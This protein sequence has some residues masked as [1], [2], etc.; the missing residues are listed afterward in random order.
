MVKRCLFCGRFF[1]ADPRVKNQKA[2]WREQCKKARKQ[3]AQSNWCKNNSN[4]FKDRYWYVKEWR[5]I[6]KKKRL[7]R[8]K[9]DDTR[10]DTVKTSVFKLV[11]LIPD[12]FRNKVIQDEIMLKRIGRT[13]FFANG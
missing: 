8:R 9:T 1:Q 7:R 11:L 10:R 12:T 3:L 6:H 2:C 5:K 13:T 4:Y